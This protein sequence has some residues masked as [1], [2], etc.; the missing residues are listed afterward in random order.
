MG[1]CEAHMIL[2]RDFALSVETWRAEVSR[3]PPVDLPLHLHDSLELHKVIADRQASRAQRFGADP[4]P[5]A[6][7]RAPVLS[8]EPIL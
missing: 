6:D 2:F 3:T 1:V 5:E 8:G 7:C 4:G